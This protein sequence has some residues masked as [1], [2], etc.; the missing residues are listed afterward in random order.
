MLLDLADHL[1]LPDHKVLLALQVLVV[2]P[3]HP[4][5][6]ERQD[7]LVQ[8]A[9]L[10]L[11]DLRVPQVLRALVARLGLLVRQD[12]VDLQEQWVPLDP[13]VPQD[14][15]EQ[16]GPVDLPALNTLGKELGRM[17]LLILLM[18]ALRTT[19]VVM[20]VSKTILQE[21]MMRNLV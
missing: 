5:R 3:D 17:L 6:V 2:Q 15:A 4:G 7:P 16:Q 20:F 14:Q 9:Q 1:E 8:Q 18:T 19:A 12:R 11:V 13:V 10:G 21:M